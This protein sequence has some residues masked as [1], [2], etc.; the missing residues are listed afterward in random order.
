MMRNIHPFYFS[1]LSGIFLSFP[2]IFPW[3]WPLLFFA[4][5]PLF[6]SESCFKPDDRNLSLGLLY[7]TF[8]TW[9]LLSTWWISYVSFWG[10]L[11][12]A[13]S[14]ALLMSLVWWTSNK[15]R[16]I[17][18]AVPGY[19]SLIV[20]WITFEYIS[21][22]GILPW[23]WLTLGNGFSN[24][25]QIVQWYEFTGVLGGSVWVLLINILFFELTK[26]IKHIN[27]LKFV[28]NTFILLVTL[29]I[30][31]LISV[32]M[33][34]NYFETG[35]IRNTVVLQP[36]IDPY[37]E[38]FKGM[39]KEE[40]LQRLIQLTKQSISDSVDLI[41]APETALPTLWED[42]LMR[43]NEVINS[44]KSTIK[45]YPKANF[46]TGAITKK[47]DNPEH[48][49]NTKYKSG[50]Y[51]KNYNSTLVINGLAEVQ[52]YHK[53]I[54]VAGVEKAPFRESLNFL[55]RFM[56]DPGGAIGE[57]SPG[58]GPVILQMKSG[59]FVGPVICFESVFGNF[60]R[61]LAL[62]GCSYLIVITND[63]W[64]KRSSGVW[65]HF[66]YSRIRAIETRRSIIRSAN[67]GI[68]GFINPR[69]DVLS[70]STVS[71]TCYLRCKIRMNNKMTFY[72]I[73]GDYLG[74]I[75]AILSFTV[76]LYGL[77]K[78]RKLRI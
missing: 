56:I 52:L 17:L 53:T 14:N 54:L 35:E 20:F 61:Q 11:F 34:S 70:K 13:I 58:E 23:P 36:N 50:N 31:I 19:F 44:I 63:G 9:N 68:S 27:S 72:T 59:E 45:Y 22:R 2:W 5:V 1:L 12:I 51:S 62:K 57:L 33:F 3:G 39:S 78:R 76:V 41:V 55:P 16:N 73:Y 15:I 24:A 29:L 65:Q 10:M 64:W 8:L 18:G 75:S 77:V 42:S 71:Q 30:P 67:T 21:H 26:Q 74:E 46:I 48:L 38:K 49:K 69:G 25:I 43:N 60:V 47:D 37:A 28:V 7:P 4:F 32:Y 6:Y 66:G 40:Q